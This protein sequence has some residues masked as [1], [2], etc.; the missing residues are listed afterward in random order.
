VG[1]RVRPRARPPVTAGP[2]V[3]RARCFARRHHPG[4]AG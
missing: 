3:D 4:S 1:R 2:C